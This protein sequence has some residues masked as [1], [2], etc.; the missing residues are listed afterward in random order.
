MQFGKSSGTYRPMMGT[1]CKKIDSA[2]LKLFILLI[3]AAYTCIKMRIMRRRKGKKELY[4]I[5]ISSRTDARKKPVVLRLTRSFLIIAACVIP[6]AVLGFAVTAAITYLE[7]SRCASQAASLESAAD[8]QLVMLDTYSMELGS[9]RQAQHQYA[10]YVA[11]L[12]L[13]SEQR[14]ALAATP[15]T[16]QAGDT[17]LARFGAPETALSAYLSTNLIQQGVSPKKTPLIPMTEAINMINDDF[18]TR[19]DAQI[20]AIKKTENCS[21]Y[22]IVYDGDFE[23]DSNAVSNWADVLSIYAAKTIKDGHKFLT[24]TPEN[25]GVLCEIYNDMNEVTFETAKSP[26]DILY[27]AP[28]NIKE[29]EALTIY[30]SVN[31]LTYSEEEDKHRFSRKQKKLV[32]N[33]MSSHYYTYFAD[34]L[35]IDVYDGMRSEQIEKII[36]DLPQGTKSEALVKAAIM[37]IGHPYSRGRRGSGNYVDCSYFAWWVYNQAGIS[38][39]TTSVE[40][41]KYCYNKGYVVKTDELKPGDIIFWRKT[42]CNCGRW[43]EIHHAGIYIGKGKVIDASSSKGR[44]VMRK[45]WSDYEWKIALCARPYKEEPPAETLSAAPEA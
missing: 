32:E 31:S 21:E 33:L 29:Q 19:I 13:A 26:K 3:C 27:G 14:R 2:Y 42:T 16:G 15:D 24:I 35:G 28:Q 38:I 12:D 37:R 22:S 20:E 36:S 41:A 4:S 34:L 18:Q 11:A 30:V 6:L 17:A 1:I 9:L 8:V 23:G 39:P 25:I 45:L 43:R 7:V 10:V 40:Q 5:V 44:V